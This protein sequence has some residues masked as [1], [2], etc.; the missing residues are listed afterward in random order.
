MP[1]NP[2][3]S[4]H[5]SSYVDPQIKKRANR[6][7]KQCPRLTLSR[8]ISDC[9]EMSLPEIER[10]VGIKDTTQKSRAKKEG[11]PPNVHHDCTDLLAVRDS[12]GSAG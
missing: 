4:V 9:L 3:M 6:V 2:E 5:V 10:R 11:G 8:I 1:I 12:R 7:T